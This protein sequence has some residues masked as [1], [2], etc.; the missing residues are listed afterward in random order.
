MPLGRNASLFIEAAAL[1][2]PNRPPCL[3]AET[4]ALKVAGGRSTTA[5]S[6]SVG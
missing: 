4:Q 1:K 2:K 3:R 5:I 6:S